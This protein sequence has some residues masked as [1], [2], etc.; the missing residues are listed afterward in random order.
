MWAALA[1]GNPDEGMRRKTFALCLFAFTFAGKFINIG[2]ATA[3]IRTQLPVPME[4]EDQIA[5]Q[6][7]AEPSA[8]D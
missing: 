5:L 7:S 3:N 8:P 2:V 1:G 4:T 6:K